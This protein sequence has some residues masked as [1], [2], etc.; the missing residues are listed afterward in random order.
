MKRLFLLFLTLAL[1]LPA[2]AKQSGSQDDPRKQ[3]F[4]ISEFASLTRAD[5]DFV[6]TNFG[7]PD[8]LDE[9]EVY[10]SD[11][12][13]VGF[14]LLEDT[15]YVQEMIK[16][17]ERYLSTERDSLLALAELYPT[18]E[19]ETRLRRFDHAKVEA[20]GALVYY[21]LLDPELMEAASAAMK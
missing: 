3:L 13:E 20:R 15:R 19:L 8:Y 14:F 11:K 18:N 4:S 5:D 12:G 17:I 21:L 9:G 16:S 6:E 1:F 10:F 7:D 2:C